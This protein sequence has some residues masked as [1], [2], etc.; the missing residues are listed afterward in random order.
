MPIARAPQLERVEQHE[1]TRGVGKMIVATQ[2]MSHAHDRIVDGVAEKE[3]GRTVLA[4]NDEIADVARRKFLR[5]VNQVVEF[6]QGVLGHGKPQRGPKSA[7][8]PVRALCR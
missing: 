8:L 2:Y 1:L 6:D 4:A 3:G 5:A 7:C